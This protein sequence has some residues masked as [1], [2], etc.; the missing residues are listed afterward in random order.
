MTNRLKTKS[1]KQTKKQG[2]R[3]LTTSTACAF[4]LHFFDYIN[5]VKCPRII[6]YYD[7]SNY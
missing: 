5:L 3:V 7:Y 6:K 1:V 4:F 2:K